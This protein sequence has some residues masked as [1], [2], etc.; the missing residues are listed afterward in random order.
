MRHGDIRHGRLTGAGIEEARSIQD[1]LLKHGADPS[2][3]AAYSADNA[4]SV[5]SVTATLIPTAAP[6]DLERSARG[7]IG[8]GRLNLDKRLRYTKFGNTD[9][10]I[11]RA[12]QTA[13]DASQTLA[14]YINESDKY[15]EIDPSYNTYSTTAKAMA[16]IIIDRCMLQTNTINCAKQFH[17]PVLHAKLIEQ[18]HGTNQRDEYAEWYCREKEPSQHAR[19]DLNV[20]HSRGNNL[21]LIDDYEALTVSTYNLQTILESRP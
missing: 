10:A 2:A 15:L 17:W 13:Y 5:L 8:C 21:T 11:S 16:Q 3:L 4:Q 18:L 20:I 9:S 12:Y 1:K 6:N 19:T 7:L 14:F